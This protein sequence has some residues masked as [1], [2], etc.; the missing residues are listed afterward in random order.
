MTELWTSV[1]D[2][3]YSLTARESQL[4]LGSEGITTY[5]SSNCTLDDAAIAKQFLTEKVHCHYF[6]F[7]FAVIL[8]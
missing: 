8:L 4:G 6:D 3:M 5:F 2:I 1:G 7:P